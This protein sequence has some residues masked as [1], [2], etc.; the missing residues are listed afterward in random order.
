MNQNELLEYAKRNGVRG[1][2]LLTILGKNQQFI[3]A[4]NTPVG[5]EFLK[6]LTA[7]AESNRII[8]DKMDIDSSSSKFIEARAKYNESQDLLF[9]FLE[10]FENHNKQLEELNAGL[11]K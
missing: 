9:S 11:T 1:K 6:F 4:I 8:F 5:V 7:R 3:N 2:R 10:I